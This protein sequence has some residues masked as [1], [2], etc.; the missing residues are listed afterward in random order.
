LSIYNDF[1][2]HH[3]TIIVLESAQNGTALLNNT[4]SLTTSNM[5]INIIK[6]INNQSINTAVYNNIKINTELNVG[7]VIKATFFMEHFPVSYSPSAHSL[8]KNESKLTEQNNTNLILLP[9]SFNAKNLT[10][11]ISINPYLVKF[12]D[13]GCA[14]DKNYSDCEIKHL[15][16]EQIDNYQ[17]LYE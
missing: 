15:M 13:Y 4:L 10:K 3:K 5:V 11:E 16:L 7:N 12:H 2:V 8:N 14:N 9:N 17:L 6:T 1:N